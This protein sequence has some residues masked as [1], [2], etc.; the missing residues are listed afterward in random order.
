MKYTII[1]TSWNRSKL[2]LREIRRRVFI[3]EQHVPE[4]LEWDEY[5]ETS[6]HILVVDEKNNPIGT[7]RLKPDGQIG[8][9][10]VAKEWRNRG[11]GREILRNIMEQAKSSDINRVYLNAQTSAIPFYKKHGF[12]VCG[13][14]FIEAGIPHVA[15]NKTF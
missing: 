15:M 9:M 7:G 12:T 6:F 3:E 5:G 14:E 13:A 11:I 4:H 8:R 10:A 2:Y 1:S